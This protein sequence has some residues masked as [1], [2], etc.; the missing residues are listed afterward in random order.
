MSALQCLAEERYE[1]FDRDPAWDAHNN[2]ASVPEPQQMRQDFGF[3]ETQYAGGMAAGE[4]GGFLTPAA[5]PAYY[6]KPVKRATFNDRLEAAGTV[7]CIG[8]QFHVLV[9]FFNST[10]INEWRIPNS[11]V[12]RLYGRGDIFYAYVEYATSKWRAGGD[13][14]GGFGTTADPAT[15]RRQLQGFAA[16]GTSHKWSLTYDPD[17]NDGGGTLTVTIDD[18]TAIC[19]LD[20]GH[21]QDGASF[22]R[23]GMLNIPKSYDQGGEVWIDDVTINGHQENFNTDPGWEAVGNRRTYTTEHVRPRFDFGFSATNFAGGERAGEFGGVIFRGDCRYPDRL[24][25]C[26]DRLETLSLDKP[27]R[28]AGKVALRRGVSDSTVLLGFFHSQDSIAFSQSQSSGFPVNFLGVAIEGPSREGFQFYPAYRLAD[29]TEGYSR[30]PDAPHIFPDGRSTDWSFEY[31]PQA[32]EEAGRITVTHDGRS[33]TLDLTP[34]QRGSSARFDRFGIVSTWIDG[35]A[36]TVYFDDLTYTYRQVARA[37]DPRPGNVSQRDSSAAIEEQ[38]QPEIKIDFDR[39]RQLLRKK[40]RGER[41]S[42]DEEAYLRRAIEERRRSQRGNARGGDR[43]TLPA[44]EKT[45]LKPLNEMSADD[46]Y[47]DQDG[48]L[49]GHGMNEPPPEHRQAAERALAMIQPLSAAGAPAANGRIVLVSISMSNAT[50]EFSRFKQIADSDPRK[51]TRLTIVDCAQGGQAMAEWVKPDARPWAEADRRLERANVKPAQVQVAWIKLA[52]KRPRGDLQTHGRQLQQDTLAVIQNA[53][54]KFPNLRIA[55]LSSR[56][57]GGYSGGPLNPEPFAYESAFPVRWLIQDQMQ[58]I[59]ELN[60][61][62]AHRPDK[63]VK[64]PLLLWGPYLWADGVTPRKSDGLT[65]KRADLGTDGTH[66]S[67]AGRDKVAR[68]LL[69]FFKED[70]LANSWFDSSGE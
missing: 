61:D 2:H 41:L 20:P 56:I 48:G 40:Q 46:R 8:R 62:S 22:D 28:A 34:R 23:F 43:R 3:S 64:A 35:N 66:P 25:Y 67:Q 44:A 26:G 51:S 18:E 58:G 33:V 52:N 54:A 65:W 70:A 31:N 49:Y 42:D 59:A 24:A 50:Q 13:S 53:K 1:T 4:I 69:S 36:Q 16:R 30:A 21:K 10:T 7:A 68:M 60:Y 9:G 38:Q 29:G 19:L 14:P 5:E 27:L 12:L 45:G 55:Y 6:A 11:L 17:G 47:L 37:E 39:A 63:P 57:Y 32:A 15:G